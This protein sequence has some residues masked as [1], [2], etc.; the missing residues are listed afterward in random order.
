[1]NSRLEEIKKMKTESWFF[2]KINKSDVHLA[3]LT[4][5]ERRCKL[6]KLELKK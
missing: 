4:Q 6:I 5:T 1:M 3:K 2:E